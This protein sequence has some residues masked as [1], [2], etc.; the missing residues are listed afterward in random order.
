MPKAKKQKKRKIPFK[1]AG[2]IAKNRRAQNIQ[3]GQL[4]MPIPFPDIPDPMGEMGKP[5]RR[6]SKDVKEP[7]GAF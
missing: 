7:K 4:G 1:V 5:K 3:A 6:K 2:A